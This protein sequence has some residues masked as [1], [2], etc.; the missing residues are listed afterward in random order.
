VFCG[1]MWGLFLLVVVV[2][3]SSCGGLGVYCTFWL[4]YGRGALG[5]SFVG[6]WNIKILIWWM[7]M[8]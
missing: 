6:V 8:C 2:F 3:N 5:V 1:V 4:G 7:I